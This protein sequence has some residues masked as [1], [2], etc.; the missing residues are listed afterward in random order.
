M[1]DYGPTPRIKR[2]NPIP[3][4]KREKPGQRVSSLEVLEEALIGK[5]IYYAGDIAGKQAAMIAY[6]YGLRDEEK[7]KHVKNF[8]QNEAR[9][10][11]FR[12]LNLLRFSEEGLPDV[13]IEAERPEV[14]ER[15]EMLNMKLRQLREAN[16]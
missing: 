3:R 9:E 5:L 14:V 6:N 10:D 4:I 2:I 11:T 1:P 13:T 15:E 12:F 8:A 16:I 7:R